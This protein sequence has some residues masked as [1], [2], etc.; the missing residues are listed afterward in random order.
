MTGNN[1][2]AEG[3]SCNWDEIIRTSASVTEEK[4]AGGG[5]ERKEAADFGRF[6]AWIRFRTKILRPGAVSLAESSAGSQA[7]SGGTCLVSKTI[8]EDVHIWRKL[9]MMTS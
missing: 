3:A 4:H 6:R 5:C 2:L 7:P 9:E 1:Q 8:G